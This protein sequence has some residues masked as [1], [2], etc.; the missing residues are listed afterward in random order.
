MARVSDQQWEDAFRAAGYPRE[1]QQRYVA[2]LKAKIRDGL[3][4]APS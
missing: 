4:L 1:T 3:A 2:K